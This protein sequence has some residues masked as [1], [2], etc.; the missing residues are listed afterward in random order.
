MKDTKFINVLGLVVVLLCFVY[1]FVK[2]LD[3]GLI[4]IVAAVVSYF[5]G[6]SSGSQKKDD[7]IANM[8]NQPPSIVGKSENT[9]IN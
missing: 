8:S 6:S 5:Y 1:F 7:T 3:N 4:A 9:T 2:G